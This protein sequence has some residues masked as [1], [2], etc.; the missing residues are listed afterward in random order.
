MLIKKF[1]GEVGAIFPDNCLEFRIKGKLSELLI[2][3]VGYNK[4]NKQA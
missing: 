2:S 4:Y 3:L 1:G